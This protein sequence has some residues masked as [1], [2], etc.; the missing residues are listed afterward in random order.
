MALREFESATTPDVLSRLD[1]EV[2]CVRGTPFVEIIKFA[3]DNRVDMIVMGTHGHN[4]LESAL[5]G[6]TAEKVV[7]KAP[8]PVFTVRKPGYRFVMPAVG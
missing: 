4:A 1:Y 6:S 8:C 3:R 5:M 2:S 7:R